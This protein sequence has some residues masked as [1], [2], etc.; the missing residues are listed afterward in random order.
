MTGHYRRRMTAA[1][2]ALTV[3]TACPAT[4]RAVVPHVLPSEPGARRGGT[5][6][7]A[8]AE[9]VDSLDPNRAAQPSSWFFVRAMHR[10]LYAFADTTDA[11]GSTPVPDLA[12]SF[13]G[14]IA[15]RGRHN[16]LRP[17]ARALAG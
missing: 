6:R 14:T 7:V 16:V 4:K 2:A 10:G 12:S 8:L 3:L 13:S 5:L 17:R 11:G 1:L 15:G 9:D